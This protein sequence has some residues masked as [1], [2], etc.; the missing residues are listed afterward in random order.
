MRSTLFGP[1]L[2][3]FCMA[4]AS[5]ASCG[6]ICPDFMYESGD[7]AV[8]SSTDNAQIWNT[9]SGECHVNMDADLKIVSYMSL[10]FSFGVT[11]AVRH[12]IGNECWNHVP[13][14]VA[15]AII[16]NDHHFNTDSICDSHP[17]NS[18]SLGWEMRYVM[19]T[20][21]YDDCASL[22]ALHEDYLI[23]CTRL[24][25]DARSLATSAYLLFLTIGMILVCAL[26]CCAL[27]GW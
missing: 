8:C 5:G 14:N 24:H 27:W 15:V 17:K 25:A 22:V 26:P 21:G 23:S 1:G 10:I 6:P 13:E 3:F 2:L 18:P 12:P 19:E 20:T 4:S 7:L 9:T 16:Q 11:L